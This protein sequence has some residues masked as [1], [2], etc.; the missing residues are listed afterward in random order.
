MLLAEETKILR[1]W[2]LGRCK[3]WLL[4]SVR[5]EIGWD[6]RSGESGGSMSSRSG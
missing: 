2:V 3:R 1:S 4:R 6:V 5:L